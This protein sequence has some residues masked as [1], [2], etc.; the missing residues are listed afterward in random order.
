MTWNLEKTSKISER[1]NHAL[2]ISTSKYA[3]K[4][5][6]SAGIGKKWQSTNNPRSLLLQAYPYSIS[7]MGTDPLPHSVD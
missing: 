2:Q 7:A 5:P 1:E 6:W 4:T 3:L